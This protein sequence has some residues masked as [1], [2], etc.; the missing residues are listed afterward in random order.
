VLEERD[1]VVDAVELEPRDGVTVLNRVEERPHD[2]DQHDQGV[3][4]QGWAY[5]DEDGALVAQ[6]FVHW[7]SFGCG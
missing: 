2:R 6:D 4:Q 5:E 7:G 1:E 3:D